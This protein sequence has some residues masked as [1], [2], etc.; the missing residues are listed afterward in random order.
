M[1]IVNLAINHA[2]LYEFLYCYHF[3]VNK[4]SYIRLIIDKFI[5][6]LNRQFSRNRLNMQ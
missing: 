2:I 1:E 4:V 3:L 5:C 6:E